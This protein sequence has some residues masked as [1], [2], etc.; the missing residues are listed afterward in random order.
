MVQALGLDDAWFIQAYPDITLDPGSSTVGHARE[1]L[2]GGN[3]QRALH[4][5]AWCV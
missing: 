2:Q 3:G 5:V 1:V 4:R